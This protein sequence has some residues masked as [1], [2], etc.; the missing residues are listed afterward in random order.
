MAFE[1][2]VLTITKPA[3]A[4]VVNVHRFVVMSGTSCLQAGVAGVALGVSQNVTTGVAGEAVSIM[5]QGVSRIEASAAI[6]VG[7]RVAP[8][9]AG[10][11]RTAVS[12][13]TVAGIALEAASAD[14]QIIAIQLQ[15]A[16]APLP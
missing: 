9:A 16:Q 2:N 11:A 1:N 7:A 15:T 5:T 8:A 12:G 3:T 13:D 10:K 6:A 14:G 4:A